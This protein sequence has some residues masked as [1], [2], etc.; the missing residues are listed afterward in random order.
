MEVL[1][2]AVVNGVS[3]AIF[4]NEFLTDLESEFASRPKTV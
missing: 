3:K 2:L 4:A 1:G